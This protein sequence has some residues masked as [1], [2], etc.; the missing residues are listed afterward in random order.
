M[1]KLCLLSH[2]QPS[3]N[4]RLVRDANIL[5]DSGYTVKVITPAWEDLWNLYDQSIIKNVKWEH[6][7]INCRKNFWFSNW[8]KLRHRFFYMVSNFI[9]SEEIVSC[10]CNYV[11]P[12]M[13]EIAAQEKADLYIAYQH[14]SLPAAAF[15]AQRSNSRFA[16]DIQDL[17]ADCSNEPI[18]LITYIEQ[19]YLHQCAYISTMSDVA[20]KRIKDTNNLSNTPIVLHNVPLLEEGTEIT[21]PKQRSSSKIISIY[22]FGQ[23]IGFHSR[24]DQVVK[25]MPLLSKPVQLVLRGQSNQEFVNY[26]CK[27]ADS[28]GV[29]EY[30]HILPTASP[31][32]MVVLASE[33][34]ILLG[35]QPGQ[36]LFHQM[37][38]GNKVFTGMMAG[39]AL[40]LTNTIAH[41]D[42]LLE[43]SGCG[44]LFPDGDEKAFADCL[45][46]LLYIPEKL[47]K[48]KQR[49][50]EISQQKFNWDIQSNVMLDVINRITH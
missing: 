45:N 14:H 18:R 20:A 26:L 32:K 25:A 8:I 9:L 38:I 43:I 19:L 33:H 44:F 7:S 2:G 49:S 46:E 41:R 11:N 23:T 31:E 28:L 24:A 39:L 42:L 35:T 40:A 34:D 21:M 4:P 13:G 3:R 12:E 27:L 48:M 36:E 37:A 30:L 5:A 6:I 10:A 29:K 16:V 1:K 47:Q 22:W 15:A 17:L 50:W